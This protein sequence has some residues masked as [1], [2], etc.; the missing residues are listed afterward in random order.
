MTTQR[1]LLDEEDF[2]TESFDPVTITG[3]FNCL[4]CLG[5]SVGPVKCSKC[6]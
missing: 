5:V 2:D 4:L 6:D 3:P 1:L